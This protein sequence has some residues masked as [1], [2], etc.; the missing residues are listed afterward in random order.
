MPSANPPYTARC[1]AR[2]AARAWGGSS[3]GRAS[4]SQCEGRGFDPLP[5][6][7]F[8]IQRRPAPPSE[9]WVEPARVFVEV[10]RPGPTPSD[11]IRATV[12][13]ALGASG[14]LRMIISGLG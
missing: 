1:D 8:L 10:L 6:H 12:G 13:A 5:L 14:Y 2:I 4:R 7:Q 3:V 9:H 11:D